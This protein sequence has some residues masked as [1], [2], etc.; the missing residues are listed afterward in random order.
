MCV[1]GGGGGGGGWTDGCV[2]CVH[3]K[4]KVFNVVKRS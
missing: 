1:C 2:L 4:C 3:M